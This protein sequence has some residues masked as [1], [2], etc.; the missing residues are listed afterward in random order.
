MKILYQNPTFKLFSGEDPTYSALEILYSCED[1]MAN[2]DIKDDKDKIS[3]VRSNLKSGSKAATT[4][5]AS[6]F[7]SHHLKNNYAEFKSNFLEVLTHF[8]GSFVWL[9]L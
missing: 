5:S 4:M 7:C 2:P 8:N 9:M 1:A 3:F 6:V